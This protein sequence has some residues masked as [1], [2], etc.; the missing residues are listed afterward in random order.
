MLVNLTSTGNELTGYRNFSQ[1]SSFVRSVEDSEAQKIYCENFLSSFDYNDVPKVIKIIL[2][3]LRLRSTLTI[4]ESDFDL[5][6]R[7]FFRE[8]IDAATVNKIV[9][10]DNKVLKCFLTIESV[11]STIP[12]DRFAITSK[13]FDSHNFILTI[14]RI[15]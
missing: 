8:E 3:K 2:N 7:Q 14:K 9:F 5:I 4:I 13:T 1:I 6:S 15:A 12:S 11:E 10:Q